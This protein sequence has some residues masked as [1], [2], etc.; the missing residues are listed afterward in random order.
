M[1]GLLRNKQKFTYKN[2]LGKVAAVDD[3]GNYTGEVSVTY[4]N[5]IE[6]W[7]NISPATGTTY[8]EIFGTLTDYDK[9]IVS[10]DSWIEIDENSVLWVDT[11]YGANVPHDYIVKRVSKG[12]N[13]VAIAISKV[14]VRI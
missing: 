4:S 7:A 14:K 8:N 1:R 6:V 5:P 9:V 13:G 2:Y 12:L 11:A 10:T 3:E